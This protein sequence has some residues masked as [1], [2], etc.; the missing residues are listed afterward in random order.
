M[1]ALDAERVHEFQKVAD[2][3]LRLVGMIGFVRVS[4]ADHVER[5]DAEV[6]RV[7]CHIFQVGLKV[8]AA[9]MQED[10]CFRIRAARFE[11]ARAYVAGLHI[12]HTVL[13]FRQLEPH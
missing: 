5:D 10:E 7:R 2:V 3:V 1:G 13:A 4:M 11:V 8:P 12:G 9:A 6:L